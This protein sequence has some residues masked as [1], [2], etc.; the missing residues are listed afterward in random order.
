MREEGVP[1][2]ADDLIVTVGGQQA[3]ELIAT[4]F[5]DPGDIVIAEGPTYVGGIGALTSLQA[6]VRHVP[7]DDD[8][9]RSIC[10]RSCS[11]SSRA[12]D[13]ARSTST[14]SR[15]TRTPPACRCRSSAAPLAELAVDRTTC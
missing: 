5:V 3:L 1:A 8:G 15:T 13:G 7:M 10:S 11:S 6:D 14:R 12:K 2:H 4:C 9:M